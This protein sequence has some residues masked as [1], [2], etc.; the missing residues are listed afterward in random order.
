MKCLALGVCAAGLGVELRAAVYSAIAGV[1]VAFSLLVLAGVVSLCWSLIV[2]LVLYLQLV[3]LELMLFG[4]TYGR[5]LQQRICD[6]C[7]Q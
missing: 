1:K 7:R 5:N 2:I 4:S 3:L 6:A